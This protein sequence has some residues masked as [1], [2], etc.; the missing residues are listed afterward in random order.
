MKSFSEVND[1]LQVLLK[2]NPRE[3]K[4][5]VLGKIKNRIEFLR[6]IRNY[7]LASPTEEFVTSEIARIENK[8]NATMSLFDAKLYKDPK[9]AMHKYERENKIPHLRE[10]IRALRFILN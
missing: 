5:T 6:L 3:T 8:I 1:E 7:L 10:Q 4:R 2:T 9:P